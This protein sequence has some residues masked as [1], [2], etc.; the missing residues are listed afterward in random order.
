VNT[1]K[2]QCHFPHIFVVSEVIPPPPH[3]FKVLYPIFMNIE[4]YVEVEAN[5]SC[6][7]TL[8]SLPKTDFLEIMKLPHRS[9]LQAQG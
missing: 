9:K 2:F 5:S 3:P 6:K 1:R 4:N 7:S 8:D